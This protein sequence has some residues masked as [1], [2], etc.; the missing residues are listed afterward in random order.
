MATTLG[1][2]AALAFVPPAAFLPDAA[3]ALVGVLLYVALVGVIRPAGLRNA[4]FYL[5][6]LR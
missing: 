2:V 6:D 3:A 5:R 1:S 4:W